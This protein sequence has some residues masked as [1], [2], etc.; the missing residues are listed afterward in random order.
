M[1]RRRFEYGESLIVT[2]AGMVQRID[3]FEPVT[4]AI[5][6]RVIFEALDRLQ[7]LER[8]AVALTAD[9]MG[10]VT[11]TGRVAVRV[12]VCRKVSR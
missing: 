4:G 12:V 7:T 9:S 5:I 10:R 11:E 8:D 3:A 6:R 1:I 2:D